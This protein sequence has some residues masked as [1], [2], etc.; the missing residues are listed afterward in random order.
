MGYNPNQLKDLV[1]RVLLDL[2]LYSDE[3]VALLLGTCAKESE[4]GYF[5]RQVKGPAMGLFQIEPATER[6]NW[7]NFLAYK[8]VLSEKIKS[9]TGHAGP[10]KWLEYDI[11]YGIIHARVKYYRAPGKIPTSVSGQAAFWKEHY[12]TSGGKGTEAEYIACYN[13]LLLGK[14]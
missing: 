7:D 6:D 1:S 5:L 2:G 4:L 12:N 14:I 10:G 8:P 13:R 3:S 11:A 9:I